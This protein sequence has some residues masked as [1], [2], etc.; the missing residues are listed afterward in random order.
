MRIRISPLM[1]MY[2]MTE[3]GQAIMPILFALADWVKEHG[4]KLR[5]PKLR[6]CLSSCGALTSAAGA[7]VL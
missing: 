2:R 3:L 7:Q 1:F 4:P 6:A 5:I